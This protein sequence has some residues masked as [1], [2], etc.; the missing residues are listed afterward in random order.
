MYGVTK[1]RHFCIFYPHCS[2]NS[3]DDIMGNHVFYQQ[4][5]AWSRTELALGLVSS[6]RTQIIT[7][8]YSSFRDSIII[9]RSEELLSDD[10]PIAAQVADVVVDISV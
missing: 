1:Q 6:N 7:E 3:R 2:A 4:G 5:Y 10:P 9:D 8:R